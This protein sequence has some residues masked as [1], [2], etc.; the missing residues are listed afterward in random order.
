LNQ[1]SSDPGP[2]SWRKY[3]AGADQA[4]MA[5]ESETERQF[6]GGTWST[7]KAGGTGE[8]VRRS[9][10]SWSRIEGRTGLA[11][12]SWGCQ[13][14]DGGYEGTKGVV[15]RGCGGENKA[16]SVDWRPRGYM[17]GWQRG[18]GRGQG[19]SNGVHRRNARGSERE[20]R[21]RDR[22]RRKANCRVGAIWRRRWAVVGWLVGK[23]EV[24]PCG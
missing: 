22:S 8:A 13:A 12:G 16:G 18:A 17:A 9:L 24:P 14:R 21:V 10:R 19:A 4:T 6:A 1:T 15:G 5:L 7:V 2:G 20:G 23:W 3:Q 11:R